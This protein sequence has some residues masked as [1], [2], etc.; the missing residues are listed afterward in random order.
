MIPFPQ[1]VI[2][3]LRT[4]SILVMV[5]LMLNGCISKPL[6]PYT[7]DT[8]PLMRVPAIQ[9]LEQDK[10]GR[11]KE[12]FCAVLEARKDT[13]P[14]YMPCEEALTSLGQT[15]EG[16][17]KS[18]NL[19]PSQRPLQV[20][21]IPGL[22]RD[23]VSEWLAEEDTIPTHLSQFGYQWHSP[24]I[25]GLAS[26]RHN[27]KYIRDLVMATPPLGEY[28]DLLLIGYSK[29]ATDTLEALIL[30]PEIQPRI[31]AMVSVSGAIGGSPLA[32]EFSD[33]VVNLLELF[34]GATCEADDQGALSDLQPATRQTWL[35]QNKLPPSIPY[36]S[37][38]SYPSPDNI[39]S[40]L[41]ISYNKLAKVDARNDG[42]IIFYDQFIPNSYL[43]A[44]L[45][46]DHWAISTA[47]ARTHNLI[48]HT[49]ANRNNYPREA[50][51]EALLRLI[52]EDLET[53]E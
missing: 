36:Y 27:A 30:Y 3:S 48:G 40:A 16:N 33:G 6:H 51:Y 21:F 34:P 5:G 46:A 22:G 32:N 11:F 24:R 20:V 15:P 8:P 47:I 39:S 50:M 9:H 28:P 1:H 53:V 44:Y 41:K 2:K 42:Q 18:V 19:G 35:A 23:C 25:N 38:I 7:T 26:G 17:G 43:V 31:A 14:D 4:S 29:G 12:I 10:R 52:E 45:N 49:F 37:L 13:I